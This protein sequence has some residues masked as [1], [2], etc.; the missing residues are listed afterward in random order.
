[1]KGT[2]RKRGTTYSVIVDL[3]RGAD[4]KRRQKWITAG[5]TRREAERK[6]SEVM[7]S[8]HQGGL[9]E[10]S[11]ETASQYLERW[12]ET[13]VKHT[14]R[15]KT[16]ASYSMIVRLYI[17]PVIGGVKMQTLKPAHIQSVI[18]GVLEKGLSPTTARRA[19]AT[20]HVAFKAAVEWDLIHRNPC[21]SL[22]PPKQAHHEISPPS[23]ATVHLLLEAAK[24]GPYYVPFQLLAYT[25]ARRGEICGVRNQDVDLE[26]GTLS[27]A[28]TVARLDGVLAI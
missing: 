14:R 11:R 8:A 16:Y 1:M 2:I 26:N 22:K 5:R 28:N 18:A 7:H 9:M 6:L 19:W 13:E 25:G 4:G 10:P 20:M 15:P 24:D 17:Q 21:D 3:P 27:I 23:K 12:L